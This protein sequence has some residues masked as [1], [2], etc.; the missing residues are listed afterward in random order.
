MKQFADTF[1]FLTLLNPKDSAHT[2][3]LA[4]SSGVA[5]IVTTEWVLTE[6]ADALALRNM[7]QSFIDLHQIL[8]AGLDVQIVPASAE[9]FARGVELYAARPGK[10]WSLTD[11][12]SFVVI[13]DCG[14]TDAPTGDHHFEPAGF[15][16]LLI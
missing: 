15:R 13:A 12:L 3:A 6:V 9:L 10:D 2:A 1:Y 8:R 5:G 16:A 11:C 4:H 14:I 7:R